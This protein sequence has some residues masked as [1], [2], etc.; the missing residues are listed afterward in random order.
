MIARALVRWLVSMRLVVL[1]GLCVPANDNRR[2][3]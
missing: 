2:N 3:G 1:L